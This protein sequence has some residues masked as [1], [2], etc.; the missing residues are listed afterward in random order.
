LARSVPEMG[1]FHS[2]FFPIRFTRDELN[3]DFHASGIAS[4][5]HNEDIRQILGK[6]LETAG[7]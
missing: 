5:Q 2:K 4:Q 7:N 1:K 6:F 3:L